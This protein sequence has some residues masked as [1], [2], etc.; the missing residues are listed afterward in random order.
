M[1]LRTLTETVPALIVKRRFQDAETTLQQAHREAEKRRDLETL[2]HVYA[3]FVQLYSSF[4]PPRVEEAESFSLERERI[5]P[6]AYN[7]LQTAMVLYHVTRDPKRA[8]EK[9]RAAIETSRKE[10]DFTTMYSVLSLL[11][12]CLLDLNETAE[13]GAVLN[14]ME[15]MIAT[16]KPIVVGDETPFLEKAFDRNLEKTT[17]RRIA[18]VLAPRCRD[19]KFG[20]R[21]AALAE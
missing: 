15:R 2:E 7:R 12:Q 10:N 18:G 9:L 16:R 5:K 21:L 6:S 13:A 14:D 3:L 8:V 4:E 19:P 1:D 11:G 20:Q 17:V